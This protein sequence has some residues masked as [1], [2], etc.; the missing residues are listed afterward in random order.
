MKTQKEVQEGLNQ[1]LKKIRDT[2]DGIQF[3]PF[4][5]YEE[6]RK[7]VFLWKREREIVNDI[8]RLEGKPVVNIHK[9]RLPYLG[10]DGKI[11]F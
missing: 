5:S 7:M 3:D 2:L 6:S 11:R 9:E 1:S 8:N 4:R 10:P